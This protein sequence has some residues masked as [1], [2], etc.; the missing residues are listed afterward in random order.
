MCFEFPIWNPL[1]SWEIC[2]ARKCL[3]NVC[4]NVG[5]EHTETLVKYRLNP[6]TSTMQ[7]G[8]R[9]QTQCLD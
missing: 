5:K 1:V 9:S 6:A 8:Q 2:A 3:V 4:L 7:D